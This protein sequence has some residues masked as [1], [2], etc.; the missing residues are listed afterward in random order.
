MIDAKE[1]NEMG[2]D[3][4]IVIK[5]IGEIKA[6]GYFATGICF[7]IIIALIHQTIVSNKKKTLG[8]NK[9]TFDGSKKALSKEAKRNKAENIQTDSQQMALGKEDI[10]SPLNSLNDNVHEKGCN[11]E[12]IIT[13]EDIKVSKYI[14]N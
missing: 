9:S 1:A 13:H 14:R 8:D 4:S 11:V 12:V 2:K 3:L 7:G 6:S 5:A 10:R